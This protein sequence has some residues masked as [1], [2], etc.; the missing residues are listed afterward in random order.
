MS[1]EFI[2]KTARNNHLQVTAYGINNLSCAPCL[3]FVHGFKGFK[4]WGFWNYTA[5]LFA[6]SGYFI[7]S[8]NFSHNG[9]GNNPTEF[10]ELEKF[11][12]NTISL[13]ISELNE[14]IEA[15]QNG[16]F[17]NT[18]NKKIG[19]VGHSRGGA[20]SI[21]TASKNDSVSALAVWASIADFKRYTYRQV[22]E[23]RK[24]GFM[25]AVNSRTGQIIKM[26]VSLLDDIE[27]NSHSSLNIHK[28]VQSLSIPFLII[29]GEQDVTVPIK[30]AHQLFDWSDNKNT[31]LY[32]I[33]SAGHTF[34][35]THPFTGSNDKFD[36]VLNKTL[37]F[38]NNNLFKE[39]K[40]G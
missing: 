21:I 24:K 37:K 7:L 22:E 40:D 39:K 33:P 17:G 8:F 31:E 10:T 29:H 30:E 3:I 20:V 6:G 23:W 18:E 34:N 5:N 35:I 19:L 27:N 25:E 36:R 26:N 15:Y 11:A 2:L 4:D 12:Q 28:A 16:F 38:F 1:K 9:I 13:E 14:L 32:T